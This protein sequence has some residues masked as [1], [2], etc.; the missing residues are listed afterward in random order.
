MGSSGRASYLILARASQTLQGVVRS[1]C[2]THGQLA[3]RMLLVLRVLLVRRV[4]VTGKPW[5]C[6]L[7]SRVGGTT[8]LT[9]HR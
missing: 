4:R 7:S 5:L 9:V 8:T 6:R 3:C 2:G 1:L